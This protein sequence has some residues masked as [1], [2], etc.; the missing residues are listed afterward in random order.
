SEHARRRFRLRGIHAL[1]AS[2]RVRRHHH[3]AMALLRQLEIVDEAP[4]AGDEARVL[5]PRHRLTHTE[6]IHA[7]LLHELRL[8][9]SAVLRWGGEALYPPIRAVRMEEGEQ[10]GGSGS[11]TV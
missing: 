7:C 6:L 1:D 5:D 10:G 2:M 9:R 8:P 3:D 11:S 4:A